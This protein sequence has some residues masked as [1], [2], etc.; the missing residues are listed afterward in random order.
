MILGESKRRSRKRMHIIE[1][2]DVNGDKKT[3]T[4]E[5]DNFFVTV[6][7]PGEIQI[8]TDPPRP[9]QLEK[10]CPVCEAKFDTIKDVEKHAR[11]EHGDVKQPFACDKCGRR[12]EKMERLKVH[13]FHLHTEEGQ[14]IY[15]K[16]QEK[17]NEK[18]RGI[19]L[20]AERKEIKNRKRREK[21]KQSKNENDG[22]KLVRLGNSDRWVDPNS[23]PPL[24][25]P[26]C[27]EEFDTMTRLRRHHAAMHQD[28]PYTCHTC[29]KGFTTSYNFHSHLRSHQVRF[30]F[31]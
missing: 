22:R 5:A 6:V 18:R 13:I 1:A 12:F 28:R 16:R 4:W 17:R 11:E 10:M 2:K 25:C 29:G 9:P 14:A 3:F 31:R 20:P 7:F 24:K 8:V 26:D 27:T 21:R 19:P 30:Y 15:R 23:P